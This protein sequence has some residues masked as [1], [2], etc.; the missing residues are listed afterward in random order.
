MEIQYDSYRYINWLLF[1]LAA[2]VNSVPTQLFV[3]VSPIAKRVFDI[4]EFE[5][6]LVGLFYPFSYILLLIPAN[7]IIDKMGLK[8][9]TLICNY[10]FI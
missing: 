5:V 10:F 4:T 8:L 6:N 9:G 3:G 7:Y 2:L 1:F